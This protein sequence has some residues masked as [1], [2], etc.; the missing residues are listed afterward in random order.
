MCPGGTRG[1]T[2]NP[3]INNCIVSLLTAYHYAPSSWWKAEQLSVKE[4]SLVGLGAERAGRDSSHCGHDHPG[5]PQK[6]SWIAPLSLVTQVPSFCRGFHGATPT[7]PKIETPCYRAQRVAHNG[8]IDLF[9]RR[10]LFTTKQRIV[11]ASHRWVCNLGFTI[12]CF[13]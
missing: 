11:W 10:Y 1:C 12:T 8:G 5:I 2:Q 7:D 6:E 13:S 4:E 9:F 3:A